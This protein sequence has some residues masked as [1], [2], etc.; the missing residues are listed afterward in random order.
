VIIGVTRLL[1]QLPDG[2]LINTAKWKS[3]ESM[4]LVFRLKAA[5]VARLVKPQ[6]QVLFHRFEVMVDG[7]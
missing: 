1:R 5:V 3:P 2:A 4:H 6:A 7:V